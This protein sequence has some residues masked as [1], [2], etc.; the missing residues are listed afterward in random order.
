MFQC[1]HSYGKRKKPLHVSFTVS[2]SK[3]LCNFEVLF[4]LAL[5]ILFYSKLTQTSSGQRNFQCFSPLLAFS[6][7]EEE[8]VIPTAQFSWLFFHFFPRQSI[9]LFTIGQLFSQIAFKTFWQN[10]PCLLLCSR[11]SAVW[12]SIFPTVPKRAAATAGWE[13]PSPAARLAPANLFHSASPRRSTTNKHHPTAA[14][15]EM[16]TQTL[17]PVSF[18]L[19]F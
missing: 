8:I 10:F 13:T 15:R 17:N 9:Y 14:P 3:L 1:M 7:F 12:H 18:T 4:L 5:L 16:E 11:P 6:A 2:D 19:S